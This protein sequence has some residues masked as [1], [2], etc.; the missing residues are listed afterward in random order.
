MAFDHELRLITKIVATADL[1]TVLRN[2]ISQNMF[3]NVQ[4]REIF[5]FLKEYYHNQQH[6][7]RVPTK[8]IVEE[9]FPGPLPDKDRIRETIPELCEEIRKKVMSR[10][11]RDACDEA[12]EMI[13]SRSP[14][15]ALA[16]LRAK[17]NT[18]QT[19][20]TTSRDLILADGAED[21]INDYMSQKSGGI[22]GIPWPWE[23]LNE[24]TGGIQQQDFI[25]IFGRP[26]HMKSWIATKIITHAYG[27]GA[28]RVLVYSCE[29]PPA[30]FRKRVSACIAEIDYERLKKRTLTDAEEHVYFDTLR[31]LKIE[32]QRSTRDDHSPSVMFTSDKDDMMGG[33]VSHILAKAEAFKPDLIVVDSFYRMKND[34]SGK[35]SMKWQDQYAIVQDL[36]HMTQQLDVPVIG[37]TQRTRKGEDESG[38]SHDEESLEDIA[39]ADAVGQEADLIMRVKKG[40]TLANGKVSIEIIIAGAREIIPGGMLLTISPCTAWEFNCWI[41]NAGKKVAQPESAAS[42]AENRMNVLI[43]DEPPRSANKGR[44]RKAKKKSDDEKHGVKVPGHLVY[45]QDAADADLIAFGDPGNK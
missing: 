29:M 34:R 30:Q 10:E 27:F 28:R 16:H 31:N 32:E 12:S 42:T 3:S 2:N 39:Y 14:Y 11:L 19:M 36:K 8:R 9:R 35:R 25:I 15:E 7:G 17:I 37:V 5:K 24:E 18:V 21:M 13:D 26:K 44:G 43:G 45:D 22:S 41:S 6:Y 23:K 40:A 4:A 38:G 33:G 1:R 20:V